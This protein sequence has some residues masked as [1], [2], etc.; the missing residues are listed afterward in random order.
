MYLNA[1]GF[2]YF[3]EPTT[4]INFRRTLLATL[5][6]ATGALVG[7]PFSIA[8][9]LPFVFEELFLFGKDTVSPKS[10]FSWRLKRFSRLVQCG[11]VAALLL[12]SA[13]LHFARPEIYVLSHSFPLWLL[14]PSSTAS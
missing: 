1:I 11:L 9:A 14:T 7:W 8:V 12:V 6:F 13:H 3:I 5:A 4:S 2:A 10:V